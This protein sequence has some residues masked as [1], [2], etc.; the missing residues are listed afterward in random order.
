MFCCID[1]YGTCSG[2]DIACFLSIH[3]VVIGWGQAPWLEGCG[4]DCVGRRAGGGGHGR[5][6]T[7]PTVVVVWG[8]CT[9]QPRLVQGRRDYKLVQSSLSSGLLICWRA[10][11]CKANPEFLISTSE[12]CSLRKGRL[13]R[14]VEMELPPLLPPLAEQ[15]ERY[16]TQ[17]QLLPLHDTEPAQQS[18]WVRWLKFSYYH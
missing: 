4:F 10:I 13:R 14:S 9:Q 1:Q 5:G 7:W 12:W 17:P 3:D 18:W 8:K 2:Y 6:T 15:L 11:L 16:L